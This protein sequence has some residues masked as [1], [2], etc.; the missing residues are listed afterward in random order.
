MH[1]DLKP[2]NVFLTK[3]GRVKILDFGLAKLKSDGGESGQTD[4]GTVS[5]GDA[6]GCRARDDGLHVARAGPRQAGGPAL[7]TSSPSGRSSTRCW[8]ASARSAATRR[9]TR[10]RRSYEGAAGHLADEQGRPP[11]LDRIVRHCLEKNPEERF[12]SARDVAFD[13]EALSGLSGTSTATGVRALPAEKRAVAGALLALAA[14]LGA[15]VAG[16]FVYSAGKKAGFVA[17]PAF[18]SITFSRGEVGARSSPRTARRS[19]IPPPG[20]ANP[21]RSSSIARRARN[22]G[23]FGLPSAEVLSISKIGRDGCHS[24]RAAGRRRSS[25]RAA[26]RGS[27]SRAAPRGTSWTTSSTRTGLPT[28]RTSPSCGTSARSAAW[29]T[30]SERC[31]SRLRAGSAIPGLPGWSA[32]GISRSPVPNDDGGS[33]AVVDR[34]GK[35]RTS[36]A[37]RD[38]PGPRLDAGRRR[39]LVHRRRGRLQPGCARRD[40]A[41]KVRL[42]GRVPGIS[43]IRDISQQDGRVLMTNESARSGSSRAG[44]ETT[45]S[46]SSP[47]STTPSWPTSRSDG[48]KILITESGKGAVRLLGVPARI[49]RLAGGAARRGVDRGVF[50]R[51]RVGDRDHAHGTPQIHLLPTSVGEPRELSHDGLDVFNADFLPDGKNLIFT[52]A[53]AGAER[54]STCAT[55]AGAPKAR[56]SP[57]RDIRCSADGPPDGK[58]VVVSGPDQRIYL[59]AVQG[60]EPTALRRPDSG[61]RRCAGR[62]TGGAS[63][64]R[65]R[66]VPMRFSV[67]GR[68][69]PDGALEGG[70]ARRR[71]R[72]R[73]IE[74]VS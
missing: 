67:R 32:R 16:P 26:S 51:R 34:A 59:Y 25:E 53:E 9:R 21:S 23:R 63:T 65:R 60:G 74:P 19:S 1:R 22:R 41:G 6:A 35:K 15:L 29:S 4:V 73:G 44:P 10:S 68:L 3:D 42:V 43:T 48:S 31:S 36:P 55:A 69:R 12:E 70:L 56:A 58:S 14:V 2:E 54:G 7:A 52:A 66:T 27:R 72:P 50:A 33:V 17:P 62:R 64:F 49:R 40:A 20:K 71:R 38:G 57:R 13:L 37:L 47:G 5:G 28:E 46:A 11:G 30:R 39:D 8:R 45:K 61:H 18:A 24:W